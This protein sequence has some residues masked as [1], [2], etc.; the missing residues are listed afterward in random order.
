MIR[1]QLHRQILQK[2]LRSE[3]TAFTLQSIAMA[4]AGQAVTA[5]VTSPAAAIHCMMF[6][7]LQGR[8][9]YPGAL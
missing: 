9:Q 8:Q 3:C 4:S 7:M 2:L 1:R 5:P 6:V